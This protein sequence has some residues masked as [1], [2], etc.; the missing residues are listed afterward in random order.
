MC[1]NNQVAQKVY[2]DETPM[3]AV[4]QRVR[5]ASVTVN[6]QTIAAISQG[7][8]VLLGVAKGDTDA[9]VSYMADKIP[10]I[11]I[12]SDEAGKM[13]RSIVERKGELLIVSQF[14]VVGDTHRGRRPSFENAAPPDDAKRCYESVARRIQEQGLTV[15]TGRFGATMV[16]TLEN[17][18]P[19]TI[20]LDSRRK[21]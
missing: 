21:E 4:L 16:V 5:S 3:K 14:T 19:V 9:D 20:V 2:R 7:L 6:G 17:D 8:V 15:Q 13:N 10:R 18:G 11:R 1:D 12:F